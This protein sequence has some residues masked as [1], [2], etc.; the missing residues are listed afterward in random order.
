M[1]STGYDS[2]N[3]QG[4]LEITYIF[5]IQQSVLA[6]HIG[7]HASSRRPMGM[8]MA[9]PMV[10]VVMAVPMAVAVPMVRMAVIMGVTASPRGSMGVRVAKGTD[11]NK[12]YDQP[13]NRDWL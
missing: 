9:V 2:E 1:H 4:L 10:T 8:S 7:I 12:V 6:S 11:A 5:M 3:L 13:S